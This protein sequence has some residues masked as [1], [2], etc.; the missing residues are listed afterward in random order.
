MYATKFQTKYG[1]CLLTWSERGL[2]AVILANTP[3]S[4]EKHNRYRLCSE[5]PDWVEDVKNQISLY[6]EGQ[7]LALEPLRKIKL[8]FGNISPFRRKVYEKLRALKSGEIITYN[9]LAQDAGAPGAA[10]AVG[11]AMA[12]NPFPLIVPCHRV[13]KSDGSCGAY[14][15][16]SGTKTKIELLKMEQMKGAQKDSVNKMDTATSKSSKIVA[17]R[18]KK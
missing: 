16:L 8:D 17:S 13:I 5:I 12:K 11:T 14:S 4:T 9:D 1:K 7:P 3:Y 6:F 2:S 10:R 15:A 18:G